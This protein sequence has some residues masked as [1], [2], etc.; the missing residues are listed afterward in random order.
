MPR[1]EGLDHK[2]ISF[3]AR[4][5]PWSVTS[6]MR[7][8]RN[9]LGRLFT[10]AKNRDYALRIMPKADQLK[11]EARTGTNAQWPTLQRFALTYFA[12]VQDWL[13]KTAAS[14]RASR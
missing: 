10:A 14:F 1:S 8:M 2:V 4:V 5:F 6:D 12:T 9:R 3:S 7:A 11:L 13:A